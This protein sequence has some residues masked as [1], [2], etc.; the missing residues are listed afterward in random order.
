MRNI[1]ALL[2]LLLLTSF[3]ANALLISDSGTISSTNSIEDFR[4]TIG[5]AGE[6]SISTSTKNADTEINLFR[7]DLDL[8]LDDFIENDDDGL[9]VFFGDSAITRFLDAGSYLVRV[10][11]QDFGNDDGS[12]EE[13]IGDQNDNIAR[14]FDFSLSI[15]GADPY[16]DS[17]ISNS[18]FISSTNSIEDYFF[19]VEVAGNYSAFT[20]SSVDPEINLFFD[21]GSLSLDD[22]IENDDDGFGVFFGDSVINRFLE[23]GNYRIRVSDSDFG[24]P[25]G[26]GPEI[27]GDENDNI[28]FAFDFSLSISGAKAQFGEAVN[29]PE[30]SAFALLGLGLLGLAAARRKSIA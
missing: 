25:E 23:V 30:P 21:D 19:S 10:S 2:P 22:F 7:D 5:T 29:V 12:D 26:T 17:V 13:I 4:F 3:H 27:I 24:N 8:T 6:Y 11:E 14:T 15:E 20:T 28:D 9:G 18:G 1:T 16:F